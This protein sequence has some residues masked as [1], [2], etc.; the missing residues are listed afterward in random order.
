M[1]R[2]GQTITIPNITRD[3]RAAVCAQLLKQNPDD[4]AALSQGCTVGDVLDQLLLFQPTDRL[5]IFPALAAAFG[6]Q[7]V[8]YQRGIDPIRV[9]LSQTGCAY[10]IAVDD[11][12]YLSLTAGH[13]DRKACISPRLLRYELPA[14]QPVLA[15]AEDAPRCLVERGAGGQA[16]KRARTTSP[17]E[18]F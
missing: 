1:S 5:V 11:K 13:R 10:H 8:V 15:A 7:F 4:T 12:T 17:R 3:L 16:A 2:N 6:C 9:G 14:A 18:M